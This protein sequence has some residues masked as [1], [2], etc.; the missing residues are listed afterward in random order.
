MFVFLSLSLSPSLSPLSPF[1]LSLPLSLSPSL[2]R[3][4]YV[5]HWEG[6]PLSITDF[7]SSLR[8]LGVRSGMRFSD[9]K[10]SSISVAHSLRWQGFG[11]LL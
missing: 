6:V 5:C 10:P 9:I 1:P 7:Q 11:D 3:P 2:A 8:I 4:T